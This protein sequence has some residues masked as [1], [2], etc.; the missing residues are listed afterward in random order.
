MNVHTFCVT[1]RVILTSWSI[2]YVTHLIISAHLTHRNGLLLSYYTSRYRTYTLAISLLVLCVV[3][4]YILSPSIF[5]VCFLAFYPD[6]CTVTYSLKNWCFQSYLMIVS[7]NH[8][9]FL[10]LKIV[11]RNL[12]LH[13]GLFP[14]RHT[15]LSSYVWNYLWSHHFFELKSHRYTSYALLTSSMLD[16][17]LPTP[18]IFIHA[19]P[20]TQNTKLLNC[21]LWFFTVLVMFL[22][23][24]SL[25]SR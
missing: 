7:W 16:L 15:T 11:I 13:F 9:S 12:N 24:L 1:H 3:S 10:L 6:H 17:L 8:T 18:R 22:I 5:G 14:S 20:C 21:L 2:K 25:I 19:T 4:V 23:L